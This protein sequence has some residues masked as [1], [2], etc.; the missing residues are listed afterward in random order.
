VIECTALT[1]T[2]CVDGKN[3]NAV[4]SANLH[5]KKGDMSIILGH[6]GSGKTTLLSLI[7]GLTTPDS[8]KVLIDGADSF[9]LS[10]NKLSEMRNATIGFV[11]QFASLF[12]SLTTL[13]NVLLPLSFGKKIAGDKKLGIELLEQVGL[14]DKMNVFPSQLSGGQQRR[15]AIAR[16]FINRP[17]IILADEPTGDLDIDTEAE[18]LD[19]FKNFNR[20]GTTFIIVTHNK[21]LI[22]TQ[23]NARI[24]EMTS[25]NLHEEKQN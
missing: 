20:N 10:D 7:G 16:S 3:F 11:F 21:N 6:S 14:K 22:T 17:S 12:P 1:K 2:Y 19:I 9:S 23:E 4:N 13:E 5:M 24:F 8:G 25:G 18:I 15:I